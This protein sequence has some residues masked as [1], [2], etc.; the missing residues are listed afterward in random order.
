MRNLTSTSKV[1][2]YG[3]IGMGPAGIGFLMG[4]RDTEKIKDVICFDK[5]SENTDVLNCSSLL[6][7]NC[8]CPV[9]SIVTGVGGASKISSGKISDYPAGS[10]LETFF[11]SKQQLQN[12]LKK[13]IMFLQ[14][15]IQLKKMSID[16]K[17]IEDAEKFYEKQNIK[18]KY[19]DV[20]EF[21]GQ[22]YRNFMKET[23]EELKNKGLIIFGDAN[24]H[25]ITKNNMSSIF[26]LNVNVDGKEDKFKVRKLIF[27]TGALDIEDKLIYKIIEPATDS[28]EIGL[29]VEA[30]NHVFGKVLSS[31]GDLKLKQGK[32][33]T[34]C[35]TTKGKIISYQTGGMSFLEG[36]AEPSIYT[37]YTNL[38]ILLKCSDDKLKDTF[39]NQYR[40]TYHGIPIKQSFVDYLNKH[41]S[42]NTIQSTLNTAVSDD[43]NNL[44]P[45]EI[46]YLLRDFIQKVIIEAMGIDKNSIILVAPEFK[47]IRNFNIHRDF[48]VDTDVYV[49]GAATGKFRGILQSLCSGIRCGELLRRG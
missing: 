23:I 15:K 46:N 48:E 14:D 33:R 41:K 5:G 19:Y 1:F 17:I 25:N 26:E 3:L 42:N 11:D 32:G 27:A 22:K 37:E 10:G 20:Y 34:Y 9:C 21:D 47:I 49:I 8:S 16:L 4:L 7:T 45:S 40:N 6:A 2:D 13:E 24:V 31:H 44:F 12:L 39:I 36:C 18:Y 30:P 28:F 35:V 29:R 38:A 43:I